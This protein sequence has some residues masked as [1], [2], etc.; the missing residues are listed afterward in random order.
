MSIA[1]SKILKDA[2]TY[3]SGLAEIRK[4]YI[5]KNLN[6][7]EEFLMQCFDDS[8]IYDYLNSNLNLDVRLFNN[9]GDKEIL[10]ELL[11]VSHKEGDVFLY[12]DS[13]VYQSDNEFNIRLTNYRKLLEK[14]CFYILINCRSTIVSE[15]TL[16]YYISIIQV[17]KL[18]D[19]VSLGI[20]EIP[21][22][23]IWNNEKKQM[24]YFEAKSINKEIERHNI[25]ISSHKNT[26]TK[27]TQTQKK[28]LK[29]LYF[30]WWEV[31][32][33]QVEINYSELIQ[34]FSYFTGVKINIAIAETHYK[35]S[36]NFF[37]S[38]LCLCAGKSSSNIIEVI[39]NDNVNE[40]FFIDEF[41]E[42][43]EQVIVDVGFDFDEYKK[44]LNEIINSTV[45]IELNEELMKIFKTTF[46]SEIFEK[47]SNEMLSYIGM[48]IICENKKEVAKFT[49]FISGNKG[50]FEIVRISKKQGLKLK[51]VKKYQELNKSML[52]ITESIVTSTVKNKLK[53]YKNIII[54][55]AND[56]FDLFEQR[57]ITKAVGTNI[58]RE[59]IYPFLA[60]KLS[61]NQVTNKLTTA[62]R[63]IERLKNCPT[64]LEG[65][66]QFENLCLEIIK[67]VFSDSFRNIRI[68]P[69]GRNY[70]G[71]DIRDFI[72]ANSGNHELWRDLKSFYK[73]NNII[74]ECKNFESEIGNDEFRQISDY[75]E[76]DYIGQF[77]IILTRKGLSD[78]GKI[79]QREFLSNRVK[80]LILVLAEEDIID[81]IRK[82]SQNEEPEL[83][84][85]DLKFE[86]ETT[87]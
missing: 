42:E 72:I 49:D 53:N 69:Q 36:D 85:E 74:I 70:S 25:L 5:Q 13:N 19:Y 50:I 84:L 3:L 10:K 26:L 16:K 48:N 31:Y 35:L 6:P 64:G 68:K 20:T 59:L 54:K 73:C 28:L 12:I 41:F 33:K 63:L 80:K 82:K 37:P 43:H 21:P 44:E 86:I 78:Q 71:T 7:I 11:N 38:H 67:F 27:L 17:A 65:W 76:K 51:D 8:E 77:G 15:K 60:K 56:F 52:I 55:D 47:F 34:H 24:K 2:I 32:K 29:D 22:Y 40:L 75:L 45:T 61:G 18:N 46:N 57:Y 87:A 83:I 66:K 23:R 62:Q 79:K 14:I 58:I 81:L 4:D 9:F 30:G 1:K 39:I